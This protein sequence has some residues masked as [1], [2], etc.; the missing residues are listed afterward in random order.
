MRINWRTLICNHLQWQI[1][2][3]ATARL[4]KRPPPPACQPCPWSAQP[5]HTC[6]ALQRAAAHARLEQADQTRLLDAHRTAQSV[7]QQLAQRC[8]RQRRARGWLAAAGRQAGQRSLHA[9]GS[10]TLAPRN[11]DRPQRVACRPRLPAHSCNAHWAPHLE[12]WQ[13]V[14]AG[15]RARRQLC[16]RQ[17]QRADAVASGGGRMETCGMQSKGHVRAAVQKAWHERL[18]AWQRLR[19]VGFACLAR[20]RQD[21]QNAWVLRRA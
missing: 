2:L 4:K 16:A 17:L 19:S 11:S 7:S 1:A 21:A 18:D 12:L 9:R 6:T 20:A 10:R 8:G 5:T 14:R 3:F 15:L 13:Q